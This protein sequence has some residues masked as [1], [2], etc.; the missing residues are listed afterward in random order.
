MKSFLLT[1]AVFTLAITALHAQVLPGT[2]PGV[3]PAI[4]A[5]VEAA[6]PQQ[7]AGYTALGIIAVM[8]LCRGL[9]SLRNGTGL[10]GFFTSFWFGTNTPHVL[11]A[12][13]A[14]VSLAS[15]TTGPDGK[16]AFL[17]RN[18]D[19]WFGIGEDAAKAAVQ[20]AVISYGKRA[21]VEVTS[22]K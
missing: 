17:G 10:K 7:Y 5:A 18:S 19:Q 15:C 1:L 21:P 2:I 22:G 4:Q 13:L 12:C 14:L 16:K 9:W 6:V 3:D 20:G 11:F 8:W